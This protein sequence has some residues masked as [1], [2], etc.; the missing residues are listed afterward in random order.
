M[1]GVLWRRKAYFSELGGFVETPVYQD[2]HSQCARPS[3]PAL[4]EQ[5][6]STIVIG[7][8]DTFEVDKFGNVLIAV[9][10]KE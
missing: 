10:P 7:P 6:G 9:S 4:I 8:G 2:P 5:P 1:S 3:G